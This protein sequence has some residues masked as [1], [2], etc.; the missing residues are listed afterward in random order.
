M[1]RVPVPVLVPITFLFQKRVSNSLVDPFIS[2]PALRQTRSVL[3]E[4][5][6]FSAE[7]ATGLE[8]GVER[9]GTPGTD[10]RA[11]ER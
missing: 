4:A 7:D 1:S 2:R 6:I 9:S 10:L 8:P 11:D 3:N 5:V